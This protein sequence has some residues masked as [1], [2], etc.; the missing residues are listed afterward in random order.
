MKWG[1]NSRFDQAEE[2]KSEK[3]KTSYLNDPLEKQKEELKR[4]KKVYG[5]YETP[6]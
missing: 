6:S 2:K 5:I 1:E 3:T 4:V